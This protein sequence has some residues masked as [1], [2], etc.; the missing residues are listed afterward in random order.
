MLTEKKYKALLRASLTELQM[1]T[2]LHQSDWGIANYPRWDVDQATG[3]LT[4][5]YPDGRNAVCAVQFI[6]SF[7]HRK[8]T[9]FWSWANSTVREELKQHSIA[10]RKFGETNRI[11]QLTTPG[12]SGTQQDAWE[13]VALATKLC[14]AQGAYRGPS[15][16]LYMFMTFTDV[17]LSHEPQ[18]PRTDD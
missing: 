12:W 17:Q 5:S 6:G 8:N 13:M 9:W 18:K 1:K 3:K 10:V 4:F 2:T 7:N 14:E 16:D 15:D 11:A